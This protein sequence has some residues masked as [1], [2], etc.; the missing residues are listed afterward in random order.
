MTLSPAAEL[1]PRLPRERTRVCG[2]D[3]RFPDFVLEN[4][5]RYAAS[6]ENT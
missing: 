2:R 3:C 4:V 6:L 5:L 1:L